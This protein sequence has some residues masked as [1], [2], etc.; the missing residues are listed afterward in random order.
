MCPTILLHRA[1]RWVLPSGALAGCIL[2]VTGAQACALD[3]KPSLSANGVLPTL[4]TAAPVTPAQLNAFT[5]FVFQRPYAAG[6][7]ITFEE[8]RADI[9]QSL[10]PTAMER[11]WRWQFGDG[12]IAYGWSVT[13]TYARAGTV[14]V[15]V[16]AYYPGTKQW[17]QFDLVRLRVVSPA[18]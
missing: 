11:P 13:H 2:L 8:N 16:D 4:N 1:L 6:A 18:R 10:I 14:E 12:K 15:A 9:A 5:P 17:Y 3:S 7:K